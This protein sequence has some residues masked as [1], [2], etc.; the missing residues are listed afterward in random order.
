MVDVQRYITS[1]FT[2]FGF[3]PG[4]WSRNT[5]PDSRFIFWR[6]VLHYLPSV[7]TSQFVVTSFNLSSF[8]FADGVHMAIVFIEGAGNKTLFPRDALSS[9]DISSRNSHIDIESATK[10]D[11]R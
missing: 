11:F 10:V 6:Q 7:Q 9:P 1:E 4:T 3:V 5:A 8:G 2:L